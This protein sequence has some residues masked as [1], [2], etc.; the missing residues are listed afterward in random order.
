MLLW[1]AGQ[2]VLMGEVNTESLF[3]SFFIIPTETLEVTC[4]SVLVQTEV[5]NYID[6][7]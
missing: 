3:D 1:I 6:L 5:T 4:M 7:K 2:V